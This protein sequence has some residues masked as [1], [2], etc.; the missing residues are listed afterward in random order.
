[1]P[2][3]SLGNVNVTGTTSSTDFP[4][5]NAFQHT[6]GGGNAT[7]AFITKI[8]S[9]I[10]ANLNV[11]IDG[12]NSGVTDAVLPSG[13]TISDLISECAKD[14]SNHGHFASCVAHVT[15][16]LREIRTISGQQKGAIQSCAA[17]APRRTEYFAGLS[18]KLWG[19]AHRAVP[20]SSHV[21]DA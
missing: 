14:A 5:R 10:A 11:V 3:T 9:T 16:D 6:L 18:R 20:G 7:S 12:C 17:Q 4:T 13:R 19:M 8:A 21:D 2:S 15:N 1:M